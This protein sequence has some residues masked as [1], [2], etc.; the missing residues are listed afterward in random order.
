[1]QEGAAMVRVVSTPE[2]LNGLQEALHLTPCQTAERII[3]IHVAFDVDSIARA[4]GLDVEVSR[5]ISVWSRFFRM[6][7]IAAVDETKEHLEIRKFIELVHLRTG[8]L[9]LL[10]DLPATNHKQLCDA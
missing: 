6:M 10:G 1:M 5:L 9:S 7:C 2:P 4:I 8:V 3:Q